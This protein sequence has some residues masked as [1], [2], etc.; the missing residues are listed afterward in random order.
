MAGEEVEP[1]AKWK[2]LGFILQEAKELLR[3]MNR[4]GKPHL[5]GGGRPAEAQ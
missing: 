1:V 2:H 4:E 3:A 5:R